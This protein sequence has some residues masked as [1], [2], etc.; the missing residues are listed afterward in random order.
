MGNLFDITGKIAMVTGGSKGLG[1]QIAEGL[2]EGGA[3]VI[4]ANRNETEGSSTARELRES[5]GGTL[6]AVRMDVTDAGSVRQAVAFVEEVFGTVDVLVNCAGISANTPLALE[7]E[8]I[9]LFRRILEVNVV[10]VFQCTAACVPS[11]KHRGWGR[12]IN[13][14]SIYGMVG[15][16]R[17]LYVNQ[18]DSSFGL[19]GYAASKGAVCNLTRDLASSLGKHGVTVNAILP[20]TF[21]TD[22]NRHLFQ[23][24]VLTRIE[25]R[26]P[27]GRVGGAEDLKGVA[28]F[29]ASD[30]SAYVTGQMLAVDGGWL[31]W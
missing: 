13:I 18:S 25:N 20:A 1:R 26:T 29:L 21:V 24:D 15:V 5:I 23:G 16:D 9:S 31:A 27:L 12:I 28:T 7:G 14:S 2:L 6:G 3:T 11:M 10:G 17:S 8:S 19:F 30:A 22:Q 4:V